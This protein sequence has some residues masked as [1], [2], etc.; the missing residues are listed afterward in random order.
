MPDE[1][2]PVD[3]PALH[4]NKD[5]LIAA[6]LEWCSDRSPNDPGDAELLKAIWSY[7]GDV[8]EPC[9][10]CDGECGESCAPCT[11]S[12]AHAMLD[13]FSAEWRKKHGVTV[14]TSG[15]SNE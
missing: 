15:A 14:L 8:T 4:N 3:A 11:V 13:D 10:E 5:T 1:M 9:P 7:H 2:K 6:V 12:A